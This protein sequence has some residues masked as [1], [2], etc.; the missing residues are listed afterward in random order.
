[1]PKFAR[2]TAAS[3]IGADKLNRRLSV[4]E[5]IVLGEQ[6]LRAGRVHAQAAAK[7]RFARWFKF[8]VSK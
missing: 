7:R 2:K 4:V 1:M 8:D 5:G 3:L 6:A